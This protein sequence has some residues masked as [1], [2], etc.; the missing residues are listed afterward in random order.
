[1]T[2]DF[3]ATFRSA[4]VIALMATISTLAYAEDEQESYYLSQMRE[5]SQEAQAQP[6]LEAPKS[7]NNLIAET[8]LQELAKASAEM[9][10]ADDLKPQISKPSLP[11]LKPEY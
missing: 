4:C 3:K 11:S 6:A 7:D 8:D 5:N 10:K 9:E 2:V 1:M